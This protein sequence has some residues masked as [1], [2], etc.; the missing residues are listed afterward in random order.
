MMT[1]AN[2]V[3]ESWPTVVPRIVADDPEALVAFV[4]HV[5]DAAGT[6]NDGRPSELR[7]GDSMLM[8][9]SPADRDRIPAFL[10]VYVPNTDLSYQ[11]ALSSGATSIEEPRELP[12]G[13]RRA[14]VRDRWGN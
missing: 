5:F 8:I 7:I 14:M 1:N 10:Y 11:R 6:F 13:D 12:Y 4:K 2:Y 9:S 3:P